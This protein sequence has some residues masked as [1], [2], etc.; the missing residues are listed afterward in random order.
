MKKIDMPIFSQIEKLLKEYN[1]SASAH[2][3]G[4]LNGTDSQGLNHLAK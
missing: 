3:S 4:K 2:H 1:I